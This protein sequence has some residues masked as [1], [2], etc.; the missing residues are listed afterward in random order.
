[1]KTCRLKIITANVL[2]DIDTPK[3]HYI[4]QNKKP[5]IIT[6]INKEQ[7]QLI[8]NIEVNKMKKENLETLE[9]IIEDKNQIQS[10]EIINYLEHNNQEN[11]IENEKNNNIIDTN[12]DINDL[13]TISNKNLIDEQKLNNVLNYLDNKSNVE[14]DLTNNYPYAI[15]N[16]KKGFNNSLRC[17]FKNRETRANN[18]KNSNI[19]SHKSLSISKI[20][21]NNKKIKKNYTKNNSRG[22]INLNHSNNL[23]KSFPVKNSKSSDCLQL[24]KSKKI[25]INKSIND[26]NKSKKI[27][28]LRNKKGGNPER[29]ENIS[30]IA[31]GKISEKKEFY[32]IG[33]EIDYKI[34]IDDLIIKECN[35][36]KEKEKC[37]EIFEQKLKPLRE[38]NKKLLNENNVEL[39]REDELNGELILLR[40]EY[41]KLFNKLNPKEK[42]ALN[43][44]NSN[45]NKKI[46]NNL[47]DK[48]FI[49]KQKEIEDE[50][51]I[52]N[53]QFKKGEF[54]FV[55][56]P[57]NYYKLK[58]EENKDITILLK[59]LFYSKHIT[60]L[61]NIVDKIWKFDKPFQTIY[62]LVEELLNLFNLEKN[63]RNK[64][65][66]YFYSFCKNYS[67]MNINEFK[68]EFKKTL[69]KINIYNKYI[70]M[71]KILNYY[72]SKI[73]SLMKSIGKK[74]MFGR[75]VIN[76]YKF[77]SLLYDCGISF[78]S[79]DK[80]LDEILEFFIFCMKKDRKISLFEDNNDL[81]ENNQ[82]K[83]C[84]LFDLY[85][86]SLND[87]MNEFKSNEIA[88]PYYLI[89]NYMNENDIINAEKLL[90]PILIDKNIL[91]INSIKYIDIIVLN[92]FLKLKGI[93]KNEEKIEVNTFEEE[94]VDINKFINNIYNGSNEEEKI[95]DYDHLKLKAENLIDDILKLNY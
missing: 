71:S 11:I 19:L 5:K 60:N 74:D 59:G 15:M 39:N 91:V 3:I 10:K 50:I 53:E 41:E 47:E 32:N 38:L 25:I 83:K 13:C 92:K 33:Q 90:A 31:S 64:L 18:N 62:F 67:Y 85:Y 20:S 55:T 8:Y 43:G 63:D 35:L 70:Y 16:K 84:S 30:S 56:K 93:I 21:N 95:K 7:N 22:N 45:N 44:F 66:N 27:S 37:I 42:Q 80:D 2:D 4:S 94:L 58:K 34:L 57:A 29:I 1:M 46:K 88:N 65:I 26:N 81:T 48:E 52:L 79:S 54:L 73:K 87:F 89:K 14:N 40:S 17:L 61:D 72:K 12:I 82:D 9:K 23:N 75:G 49:K 24:K 51:K 76:Y 78:N 36:V 77:M 68:E 86:E 6:H 28:L 69:G